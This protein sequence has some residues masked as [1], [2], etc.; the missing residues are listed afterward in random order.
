MLK[1][2]MDELKLVLNY[3]GL[4]ISF[5][6]SSQLSFGT[7]FCSLCERRALIHCAVLCK[8]VRPVTHSIHLFWLGS[9]F[10]L[11]AGS[12]HK[13][14]LTLYNVISVNDM[15]STVLFSRRYYVLLTINWV[16]WLT[17]LCPSLAVSSQQA[18]YW[19]SCWVRSRDN[20]NV[21]IGIDEQC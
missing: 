13:I 5:L 10:G 11:L 17:P 15:Y 4:H 18:E 2:Y 1:D 3:C 12:S 8:W 6:S 20:W 21:F 9:F 14:Q 16:P 19:H 7:E